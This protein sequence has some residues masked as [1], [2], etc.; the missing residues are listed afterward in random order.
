MRFRTFCLGLLTTLIATFAF[1]ADFPDLTPPTESTTVA[2]LLAWSDAG[3]GLAARIEHL[4]LPGP[5]S[6]GA[7][8]VRLKNTSDETLYVPSGS[9]D[10]VKWASRF[11]LYLWDDTQWRPA[12]WKSFP[13]EWERPDPPAVPLQ[14]GESVVI[15]LPS[16]LPL[17]IWSASHLKLVIRFPVAH[18][19]PSGPRRWSGNTET[20]AFPRHIDNAT[21]QQRREAI[22]L[23]THLPLQPDAGDL[24]TLLGNQSPWEPAFASLWRTQWINL[25]LLDLYPDDAVASRLEERM[26]EEDTCW[27]LL[28]ATEAVRS[29]SDKS[30]SFI[31]QQLQSLVQQCAGRVRG[32]D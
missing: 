8:Y 27:N 1:S 9:I 32:A 2:S 22:T 20:P 17:S 5:G 21:A 16:R 3:D 12:F 31:L 14:A 10:D 15:T 18:D 4:T 28:L 29:G 6:S 24:G 26:G 7:V 30:R 25:A 23:P 13:Q 11:Q 19:D